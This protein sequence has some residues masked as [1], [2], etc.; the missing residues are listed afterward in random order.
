[1]KSDLLNRLNGIYTTP[2]NDGAGLLNGKDTHTRTFAV[3]PINKE[4]AKAIKDLQ[5]KLK[6]EKEVSQ[7][8]FDR[9]REVH[10]LTKL[11]PH[12]HKVPEYIK[13]LHSKLE[14]S[15]DKTEFA[16]SAGKILKEA[17][18]IFQSKLEEANKMIEEQSRLIS[19]LNTHV[20]Q[21]LEGE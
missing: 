3:S 6:N 2:V 5:I 8:W 14:E 4:A 10:K 13:T 21:M 12:E 19:K 20:L 17:N 16:L 7:A 11:P 15:E 9:Y 18:G 1:M